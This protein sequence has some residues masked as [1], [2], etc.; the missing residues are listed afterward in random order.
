MRKKI[1]L[2]LLLSSMLVI[3][4]FYEYRSVDND[5]EQVAYNFLEAL[6]SNDPEKASSYLSAEALLA[7]KLYCTNDLVTTCI[8]NLERTEWGKFE[9][10][11]SYYSSSVYNS[12]YFTVLWSDIKSNSVVVVM[13]LEN[14]IWKVSGWRGFVNSEE[15][16]GLLSGENSTNSFPPHA[17]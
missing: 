6:L 17:K 5:K 15:S 9:G 16:E 4:Y 7:V 11:L 1:T 10:I 13:T 12:I 14:G 2:L 8:D 3:L